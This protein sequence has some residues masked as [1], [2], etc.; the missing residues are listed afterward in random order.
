MTTKTHRRKMYSA[1]ECE[2]VKISG[3]L[4]VRFELRS[5]ENFPP[6][7][8]TLIFRTLYL[9]TAQSGRVLQWAS[10]YANNYFQLLLKGGPVPL[11]SFSPPLFQ[12]EMAA[13]PTPLPDP[14][15]VDGGSHSHNGFQHALSPDHLY[16]LATVPTLPGACC[17]HRGSTPQAWAVLY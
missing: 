6:Q 9:C 1:M 11:K 3:F 12:H 10:F 5:F 17:Q 4:Q 14:G 15:P 7:K 2:S 16:L 13:F 8:W